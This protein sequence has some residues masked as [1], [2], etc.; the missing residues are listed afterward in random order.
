[1]HEVGEGLNSELHP[2]A[3]VR[4]GKISEFQ[5]VLSVEPGLLLESR[6]SVLIETRPRIFPAFEMRHPVGNINVNAID[7]ASRDLPNTLHVDLAP[8]DRVGASPHVS[9]S[10]FDPGF[11]PASK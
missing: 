3:E 10:L 11:C 9:V 7:A 4:V 5:F 8:F 6:D 2:L 1:M